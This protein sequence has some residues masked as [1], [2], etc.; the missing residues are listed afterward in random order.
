MRT[1]FRGRAFPAQVERGSER[2]EFPIARRFGAPFCQA[3]T[4][5]LFQDFGAQRRSSAA[6]EE[7][8]SQ[9]VLSR[10]SKFR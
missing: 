1:D 4:P 3:F 10:M 7:G 5:V 6:A 9:H 8:P 2:R